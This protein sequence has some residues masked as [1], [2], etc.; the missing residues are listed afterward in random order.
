[1]VMAGENRKTHLEPERKLLEIATPTLNA[2]KA[3][4]FGTF[5][6]AEGGLVG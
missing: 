3:T 6:I 5:F 4:W 1:M 2:V